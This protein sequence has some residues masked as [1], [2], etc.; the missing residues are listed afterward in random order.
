MTEMIIECNQLKR[1]IIYIVDRWCSSTFAYTIGDQVD[2]DE[3]SIQALNSDIF[4]WPADLIKPTLQLVL[5]VDDTES[6]IS[7]A[8]ATVCQIFL[9]TCTGK[10]TKT[11]ATLNLLVRVLSIHD[12]WRMPP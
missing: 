11:F 2:G 12:E 9:C 7:D 8:R 10:C 5:L 3:S 6:T 1:S 4:K